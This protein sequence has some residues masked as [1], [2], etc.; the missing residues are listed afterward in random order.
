MKAE[1]ELNGFKKEVG[2]E[3]AEIAHLTEEEMEDVSGGRKGSPKSWEIY[4]PCIGCQRWIIYTD[5]DR[6]YRCPYCGTLNN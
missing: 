6:P 4:C 2:T 1:E 5:K 3:N